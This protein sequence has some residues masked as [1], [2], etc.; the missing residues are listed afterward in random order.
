MIQ[1][2]AVD[3]HTL[4]RRPLSRHICMITRMIFKRYVA[5]QYMYSCILSLVKKSSCSNHNAVNMAD[6]KTKKRCD[7]TGVGMVVCARH[8]MRLPNGVADL[9]YGERC[10]VLYAADIVFIMHLNRTDM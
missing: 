4:W 9:Q 10:I 8:G 3:G 7:A 1:V 2:S 6:A 5:I